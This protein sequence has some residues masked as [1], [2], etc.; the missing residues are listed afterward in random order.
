MKTYQIWSEG[1]AAT[2]QSG[3][4]MFHGLA[5]GTSFIEAC[6]RFF[7]GDPYY[8]FSTNSHWSC[9]LF[10]NETAARRSFG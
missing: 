10:N 7:K 6:K 4:A 8:N 1:F 3:T 2:G 9:A 5:P